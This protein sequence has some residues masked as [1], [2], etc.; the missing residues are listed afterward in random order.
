MS[1]GEGKRAKGKRSAGPGAALAGGLVAHEGYYRVGFGF[2]FD[3][4]FQIQIPHNLNQ[5]IQNPI[6]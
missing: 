1:C 6:K 5:A 2:E 3:L 4:P